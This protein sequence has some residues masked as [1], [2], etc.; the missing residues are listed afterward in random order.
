MKLD[1][2]DLKLLNLLQTNARLTTKQLAS[3]LKLSTTPV[4]ERIKK[5]EKEG[6]IKNYSARVDRMKVGKALVVYCA[7]SLQE[8]QRDTIAQ[9]ERAIAHVNEVADCSHVSGDYDYLLKVLVHDMDEY[10]QLLRN[11]LSAING[12][13]KVQSL[14]V[15][16]EVKS[17]DFINL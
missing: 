7:V 17:T 12:I 6:V 10:R 5:L 16:N 3:E 9:F 15:M 4:H 14:F 13:G 1:E 11:K 8:H 2:I